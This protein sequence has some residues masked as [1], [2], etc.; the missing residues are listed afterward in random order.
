[1]LNVMEVT[2]FLKKQAEE[3][4]DFVVR[5]LPAWLV[6]TVTDTAWSWLGFCLDTPFTAQTSKV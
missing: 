1:M 6:V 4:R 3:R 5:F 2:A